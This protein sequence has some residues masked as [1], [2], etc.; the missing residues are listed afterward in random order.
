MIV[1]FLNQKGG[2]GKTTLALHLAGEWAG[3]GKRVTLVDADPQGS[4]LD[5]SQQRAREHAPRLFGVVGLARDTLHR[6]APELARD[7]DHVVIDGPPRVAGLMRSALLAADLVLIPVQ[8]S[9]LDGWASAEMLAL[10]SEARIY[11]PELR[12]RF[13]LNR[14]GARTVIARET[15]ETLADHDPPVLR[16][17]IGRLFK[18]EKNPIQ[19][20]KY[21]EINKIKTGLQ[22]IFAIAIDSNDRIYIAGDK[23]IRIFDDKGNILS[24]I[25]LPDFATCLTVADNGN[26]YLGMKDHIEIYDQQGKSISKWNSLGKNAVITSIAVYGDDVFVADAAG[27]IV[28]RYNLSGKFINSIGKRDPDK[29]IAGFIIPS[30]YFDLAV[31]S[32][33]LLRVVNPGAHKMEAYDFDGNPKF[34]WGETAVDIRGFSGCCNPV[35]FSILPDGRFVTCEK[36]IPRV[37]IYNAKGIFESVVAGA[38]NFAKTVGIYNPALGGDDATK[39]LD[40]AVDSKSRILILDPVEK[41]IRIFVSKN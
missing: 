13:V 29:G 8:P 22:K 30:P 18:E 15:A 3:R 5:W 39:A 34:S 26:I 2:V 23:S 41:T 20:I 27:K 4:A 9:P 17:A 19:L 10:L 6:E 31:A 7:V 1:A 38:E 12:A 40:V 28:Q 16:T 24:E 36:G 35:N 14:C 25:K 33:G 37:K 11:R 32:D 21:K